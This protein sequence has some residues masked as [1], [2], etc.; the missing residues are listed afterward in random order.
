MN[1]MQS[2]K[3]LVFH[4]CD[5]YGSAWKVG[6]AQSS[7]LSLVKVFIQASLSLETI[8]VSGD[9]CYCKGN[10]SKPVSSLR[11]HC[12]YHFQSSCV[13][14]STFHP[15]S[16]NLQCKLR[17]HI[18]WTKAWW[19]MPSQCPH[20]ACNMCGLAQHR[21]PPSPKKGIN[22]YYLVERLKERHEISITHFISLLLYFWNPGALSVLFIVLIITHLRRWRK[23]ECVKEEPS[24]INGS[25]LQ[26][27][28]L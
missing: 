1:S 7:W 18:Q 8:N 14:H 23:A 15:G 2:S 27:S 12:N 24:Q 26:E 3:L 16:E 25:F 21:A 9:Y 5:G 4:S 11:V 20:K 13:L 17:C 28:D 10:D 22:G 19:T 6:M